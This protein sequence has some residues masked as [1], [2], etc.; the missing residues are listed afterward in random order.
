MSA[1]NFSPLEGDPRLASASSSAANSRR[2]SHSSSAKPD[3]LSSINHASA[4]EHSALQSLTPT[5][6]DPLPFS[7]ARIGPGV[8]SQGAVVAVPDSELTA[9]DQAKRLAAYAAVDEHVNDSHKVIGI[10]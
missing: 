1:F 3:P 5:K 2:P 6:A 9:E 8:K 7:A 4:C 10:G